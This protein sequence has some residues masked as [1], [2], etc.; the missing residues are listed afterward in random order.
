MAKE[1]KIIKLIRMYEDGTQEYLDGEDL[2]HFIDFQSV[3]ENHAMIYDME[4]K[5]KEIKWKERKG[6]PDKHT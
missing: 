2:E 1:K 5:W 4:I 6:S 3:I